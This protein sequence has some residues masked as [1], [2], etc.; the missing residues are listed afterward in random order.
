VRLRGNW[1]YGVK[2]AFM[3]ED[4]HKWLVDVL[5]EEAVQETLDEAECP[6]CGRP[7][8]Y[9]GNEY[10]TTKEEA[11]EAEGAHFFWVPIQY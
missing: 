10:P 2:V 4:Q 5:P 6:E 8:I 9:T 3:C 11:L 7:P 1:R